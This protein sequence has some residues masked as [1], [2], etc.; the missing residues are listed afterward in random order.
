MT[1]FRRSLV[2][3]LY[4][5]AYNLER[6]KRDVGGSLK[7]TVAIE[8]ALRTDPEN[9]IHQSMQNAYH[10]NL[11]Y[12]E[13]LQLQERN[14]L[15]MRNQHHRLFYGFGNFYRLDNIHKILID[16]LGK[17]Y[18]IEDPMVIFGG[19]RMA[20][21]HPKGTHCMAL[22]PKQVAAKE[23]SFVP[24]F[25]FLNWRQ[26]KVADYTQ[27]TKEIADKG[28]LPATENEIFWMG[29][30]EGRKVLPLRH[31]LVKFGKKNAFCNFVATGANHAYD[32]RQDKKP[33]PFT[34]MADQTKNKYLLDIEGHG[35]SGRLK[36]LLHSRRPV[37]VVERPWMEY[38]HYDLK[39]WVHF[40]PVKRNLSDL[41]KNWEKVEASPDLYQHIAE[42]AFAFASAHLT[43][44]AVLNFF[45]NYFDK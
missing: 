16:A 9:F 19:D 29:N 21:A 31:L 43:Y 30:P 18:W 14:Y 7:G 28:L 2:K 22:T 12:G 1:N 35:Y 32:D 39:P 41:K 26:A 42:N 8:K 34:S 5:M 23:L 40:I 24:C 20:T 10:K 17:D 3:K 37:F 36:Y 6:N 27:T 33:I 4:R 38:W 44:P 13:W 45:R 25:T 11:L 15:N